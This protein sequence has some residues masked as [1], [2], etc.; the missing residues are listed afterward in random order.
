MND[1][2]ARVLFDQLLAATDAKDYDAFVAN[3]DETLRGALAKSQ[4]DAVSDMMTRH[5][6]HTVTFLG[7]LNKPGYEIYLYRVH[8]QDED[9]LGTMALKDGKVAGIYFK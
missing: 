4:F 8:Y 1:A 9:V 5:G 3:A 7:E 6:S 2:Q